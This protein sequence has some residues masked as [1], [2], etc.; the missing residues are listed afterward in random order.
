MTVP[1]AAAP[2][3]TTAWHPLLVALLEMFLPSGW[4]L[5]PELLLSRLPQRVDI[6]IIERTGVAPGPVSR[7]HSIFDHLRAHTLIE[8]KGPTDD[9]ASEDALVLLGYG[10]QYM[11]LKRLKEPSEV[12]LMVI[13]DHVTPGF[14]QQVARLGGRFAQV[15]TG[16]WE[17]ELAGAA[18]HGVETK[19]V[20]HTGSSE[21]LLYAFSR[22]FIDNP[23][24]GPPL[25]EEG[26]RVYSLLRDQVEQ[27]RRSRGSEPMKYEEMMQKSLDELLAPVIKAMPLEQRL[28]LITPEELASILTPEQIAAA[29][30]PEQLAEALKLA[31]LA[32]A[33]TPAQLTKALT[34][35]QILEALTPEQLM[36]VIDAMPEDAR[37]QLKRR[38]H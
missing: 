19:D 10:A 7:L 38:L 14:V 34:P 36:K 13:A 6:V 33:L 5:I 29:K 20:V 25:D 37:E 31:Q 30:T 8:H 9:L 3:A 15:G 12:C 22:A 2:E 23:R 28:A 35:E 11:R 27:L 16:L 32:R 18:L 1:D 26:R 17:G 24:G 4:Q 21:R